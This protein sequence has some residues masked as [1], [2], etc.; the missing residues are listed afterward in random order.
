MGWADSGPAPA[1]EPPE[2]LMKCTKDLLALAQQVY[3]LDYLIGLT[4]EMPLSTSFSIFLK[5][6]DPLH[7][8]S[9][10]E[11]ISGEKLLT[12]WQMEPKDLVYKRHDLPVYLW[13]NETNHM[14]LVNGRIFPPQ[15]PQQFSYMSRKEYFKLLKSSKMA[16]Q[17][18]KT[19]TIWCGI[20]KWWWFEL[21][22]VEFYEK[23]DPYLRTKVSPLTPD[24][25]TCEEVE[26]RWGINAYELENLVRRKQGLPAWKLSIGGITLANE[27]YLAQ[28]AEVSWTVKTPLSSCMFKPS[29]LKRFEDRHLKY[30]T[31]REKLER[32]DKA[33][34]LIVDYARKLHNENPDLILYD[35]Q[36]PERE[37]LV[38]K[39]KRHFSMLDTEIP[40]RWGDHK[41]YIII[42]NN[43]FP[44]RK[45]TRGG[46]PSGRIH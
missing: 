35:P 24:W 44:E 29:D 6:Y 9:R 20:A 34:K 12:R 39:T 4:K 14:E 43:L 22:H 41:F 15:V 16:L 3:A 31:R 13:S 30:K 28:P 45:N 25:R 19:S 37:T 46:R 38:S 27:Q 21:R 33:E 40:E 10:A 26:D 23:A 42:R 32:E 8:E 17:P 11:W 5:Q 1:M 7:K 36:K 2:E 18:E